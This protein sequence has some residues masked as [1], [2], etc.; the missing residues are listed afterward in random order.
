MFGGAVSPSLSGIGR[1]RERA[2]GPTR[3]LPRD[4][5]RLDLHNNREDFLFFCWRRPGGSRGPPEVSGRPGTGTSEVA[6]FAIF[7]HV[8]VLLF[9]VS[10]RIYP[11][12]LK[13]EM[14]LLG[15]RVYV[16][17]FQAV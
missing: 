7:S 4:H 17:F 8:S 1:G 12:E 2:V 10:K 3:S 14:D 13:S 5:P 15:P 11:S 6:T 16:R 9:F